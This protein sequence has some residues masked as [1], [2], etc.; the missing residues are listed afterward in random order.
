MARPPSTKHQPPSIDWPLQGTTPLGRSCDRFRTSLGQVMPFLGG[1]S[2]MQCPKG[3]P[4]R[5]VQVT[6][7]G[8]C[9]SSG[10]HGQGRAISLLTVG[11]FIVESGFTLAANGKQMQSKVSWCGRRCC[12]RSGTHPRPRAKRHTGRGRG[13]KGERAH[14]LQQ[15]LT[16]WIMSKRARI[17]ESR[18]GTTG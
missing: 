2:M 11:V 14:S 17:A 16:I 13:N 15:A 8:V 3:D 1:E 18:P 10:T 12:A 4:L 5:Q 6:R 9:V 7:D